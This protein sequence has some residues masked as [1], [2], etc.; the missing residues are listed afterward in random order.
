MKHLALIFMV[1]LTHFVSAQSFEETIRAASDAYSKTNYSESAELYSNAFK[2]QNGS[3]Q[4]YYNAACSWALTGDTVV[5]IRYIATAAKYG[6]NNVKH[7]KSDADLF[8]LHNVNDWKLVVNMVQKNTDEFEKDF[9]KPLKAKL[10]EIYVKDQMLRQLY[11]DAETK[12]GKESDEMNYFW[13]LMAEQDSL[14]EIEVIAIIEKHGWV[15]KSKVGGKANMALWLV[16]QHAAKEVQEKYLP[17]LRESVLAGE[18]SGSHLALLEDRILMGN[19][20]PQTYGSQIT[21]DEAGNQ[22]VYEIRDPEYVNK[23]RKEVGLGPIEDY[24]ARWG[25]VWT[26]EQKND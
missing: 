25:I 26:I 6:W 9:D 12:F 17:V 1:A 21:V 22:V 23:R 24:V 14:N 10:E 13:E 20:L 3:A 16:I 18:S 5:S 7:L 2:L 15:G 8:S 11:Q 4:D 19:G